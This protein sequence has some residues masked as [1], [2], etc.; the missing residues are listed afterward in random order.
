LV[1]NRVLLREDGLVWRQLHT[2]VD[3]IAPLWVETSVH[4][5]VV[6][7]SYSTTTPA[8]FRAAS[9]RGKKHAVNH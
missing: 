4:V 5:F 3:G 8:S 1:R 9:S 6:S 2:V 7:R